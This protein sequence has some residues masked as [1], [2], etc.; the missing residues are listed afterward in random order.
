MP[1]EIVGGVDWRELVN[2][3]PE[4]STAAPGQEFPFDTVDALA[5]VFPDLEALASQIDPAE[6]AEGAVSAG[7]VV[8]LYAG[9]AT[10]FGA[11]ESAVVALRGRYL[12]GRLGSCEVA[13]VALRRG[14]AATWADMEL[15]ATEGPRPPF[16]VAGAE[17]AVQAAVD[18]ATRAATVVRKL[19]AL[20]EREPAFWAVASELVG[21]IAYAYRAGRFMREAELAQRLG[22]AVEAGESAQRRGTKAGN[23]TK[24]V[25][26]QATKLR[27][28]EV[29][30]L[31]EEHLKSSAP[32]GARHWSRD[33]L[34]GE[35]H[36][37]WKLDGSAPAARTIAADLTAMGFTGGRLPLADP[38]A[39]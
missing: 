18:Q 2:W 25:R 5:T 32:G 11:F 7:Y 15:M 37:S 27:R 30:R 38:V 1:G 14:E 21:A 23:A 33:A 24:A 28:T 13:R 17:L 35:I 39:E 9:G 16:S 3:P 36:D 22:L 4:A 19:S 26:A 8:R 31:A 20:V 12:D 29:R 10:R 34:S 6:L